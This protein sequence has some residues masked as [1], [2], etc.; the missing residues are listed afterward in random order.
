MQKTI[1]FFTFLLVFWFLFSWA[2]VLIRCDPTGGDMKL[3]KV[4]AFEMLV[5]ACGRE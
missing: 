2:E 4:N 5:T 3:S 1:K